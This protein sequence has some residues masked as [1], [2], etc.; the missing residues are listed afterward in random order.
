MENL[1]IILSF[2]TFDSFKKFPLNVLVFKEEFLWLF[3]SLEKSAVIRFG[4]MCPERDCPEQKLPRAASS[5]IARS[6]RG[7]HELDLPRAIFLANAI[8]ME[9]IWPH[10]SRS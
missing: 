2:M 6:Q 8:K 7:F 1:A 4:A 3:Y 5:E 9:E 10:S